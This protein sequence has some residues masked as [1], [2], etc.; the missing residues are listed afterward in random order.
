MQWCLIAWHYDTR[1]ARAVRVASNKGPPP[2]S[3]APWVCGLVVAAV[4]DAGVVWVGLAS[5]WGEGNE[6]KIQI[7]TR[8]SH[9]VPHRTTDLA[10]WCLRAQC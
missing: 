7:V 9:V 5:P 2:G 4:V 1:P 3:C 6:A 8:G 10:Q